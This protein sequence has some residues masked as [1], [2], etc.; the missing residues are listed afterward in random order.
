MNPH[1][2]RTFLTENFSATQEKYEAFSQLSLVFPA[3]TEKKT[4]LSMNTGI[5]K[6][7]NI[8]DFLIL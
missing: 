8:T 2:G 4:N 1:T 5:Y 3:I 7:T 6:Q